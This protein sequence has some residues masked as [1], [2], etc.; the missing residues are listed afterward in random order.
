MAKGGKQG[1]HKTISVNDCTFVLRLVCINR[2]EHQGRVVWGESDVV[3]GSKI[4]LK[5][6]SVSGAWSVSWEGDWV[7]TVLLLMV[8]P[9]RNTD[10]G[11][12]EKGLGL[13]VNIIFIEFKPKFI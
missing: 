10:W 5:Q 3:T 1:C 6:V 12:P 4:I 11:T 9:S 2:I 7:N 13:Y 8:V